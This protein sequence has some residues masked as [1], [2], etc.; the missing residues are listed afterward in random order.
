MKHRDS[1]SLLLESKYRISKIMFNRHFTKF[2]MLF[3]LGLLDD[4]IWGDNYEF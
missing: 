3:E 2:F 1:F 4:K